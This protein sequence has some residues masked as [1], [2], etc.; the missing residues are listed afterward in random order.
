ML[1]GRVLQP[2]QRG[3]ERQAF[4]CRQFLLAGLRVDH[5]RRLGHGLQL[6][7]RMAD[8]CQGFLDIAAAADVPIAG[9]PNDHLYADQGHRGNWQNST[10][11][12]LI[13]RM[14]MIDRFKATCGG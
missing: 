6:G 10:K 12:R 2:A 3:V 11:G 1:V 5:V 4:A 7:E 13:D 9:L 8:I 14:K